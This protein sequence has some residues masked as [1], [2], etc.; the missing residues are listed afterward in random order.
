M[1]QTNQLMLSK[2]NF[3]LLNITNLLFVIFVIDFPFLLVHLNL[4]CF[5]VIH[6]DVWGP[7]SLSS[8]HGHK[9]LLTIVDDYSRYTW[10]F[11]LKQKFEVVK[12]LE[13]FVI[14]I[15][16]KFETTIT[17]IRSDN[18]TEF[19]MNNFFINKGIMHQTSCVNT[20]QQNSIV[21]RKHSHLLNVARALMIQSHLPKIYWSYY[22]LH[23]AH[24]INMFP[25]PIFK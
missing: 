13:N 18:E 11:P 6:V 17:V 7:Y 15:Q 1:F 23:V 9:Y 3:L 25:T 4:K 19:F 8:V 12:I 20:P 14:F 2:I 21:E 16:T 22:V 10:V 5:Y 24:I